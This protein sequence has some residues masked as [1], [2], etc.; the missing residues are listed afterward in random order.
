MKRFIITGTPGSGKTSIIRQLELQ[1]FSVVE[2]AATDVIADAQSEGISEPWRDLSFIDAIARLQ[3][4]RETRSSDPHV[5]VQFCDRSVVCTAALA[6]Y[7]GYPLSPFLNAELER[8]LNKSV[9]EKQ[10]FF[11]R[12]LGFITPTCARRISFEDSLRFE[13]IHEQTY[14]SFGFELI[15]IE[16]G[17]V[18][19]RAEAIQAALLSSKSSASTP[20]PVTNTRC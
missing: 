10:V 1:G 9:Y 11:V 14:N 6:R 8:I 16:P 13:A 18:T 17:T 19:E 12:N 4:D 3:K 5:G 20:S 2:E 7:L 15:Y